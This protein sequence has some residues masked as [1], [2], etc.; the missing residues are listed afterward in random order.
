MKVDVITGNA[1]ERLEAYALNATCVRAVMAYWTIPAGDLSGR[2]FC[3][4]VPKGQLSLCGYQSAHKY[5]RPAYLAFVW[6][7]RLVAFDDYNGEKRDRR[8]RRHAQPFDAF[9]SHRI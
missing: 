9:E 8:L 4:S 7:K 1:W 2:F 5:L 6:C 3:F